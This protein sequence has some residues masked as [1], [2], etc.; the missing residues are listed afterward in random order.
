M[1]GAMAL[2]QLNSRND[3][4]QGLRLNPGPQVNLP[5]YHPFFYPIRDNQAVELLFVGVPMNSNAG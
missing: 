5:M 1:E 3:A 4:L 2:L